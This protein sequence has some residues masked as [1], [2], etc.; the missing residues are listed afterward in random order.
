LPWNEEN[1]TNSLF[2]GKNDRV[3]DKMPMLAW[4]KRGVCAVA[5]V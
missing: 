3:R 2:Y 5:A 1:V 4:H